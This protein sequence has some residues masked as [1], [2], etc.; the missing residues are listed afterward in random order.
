MK[1]TCE[2]CPNRPS[3]TTLCEEIENQLRRD[4]QPSDVKTFSLSSIDKEGKGYIPED[5]SD[6]SKMVA[7]KQ[8]L[9]SD[10]QIETTNISRATKYNHVNTVFKDDDKKIKRMFFG[11]LKCNYMAQ[12]ARLMGCSRQYIQT[13]FT[14]KIKEIAALSK[15]EHVPQ[16]YSFRSPKTFKAYW[17]G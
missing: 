8:E 5:L 4:T 3:C 16:A 11:F 7:F 10:F 15:G 1:K 14:K 12:I 9:I 17:T 13:L 6:D 2:T